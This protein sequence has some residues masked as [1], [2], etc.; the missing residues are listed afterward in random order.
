MSIKDKA[1]EAG[2]KAKA[3][4]EKAKQSAE[5]AYEGARTR[6]IKAYD[7]ARDGA[8]TARRK[9]GEG[10]ESNPLVA[11]GAGLGLGLIIGALIPRSQRE[12][13][14]LR[15]VG[16]DINNRAHGAFD[17]AKSAG[18]A[19]LKER[20]I[21]PEAAENVARDVARGIGEA[22]KSSAGAAT[23]AAKRKS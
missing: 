2:D 1:A 7:G 21:T 16:R 14:A 13:E 6:A 18:E 10:L 19:Q 4:A 9:T 8:A 17:A 11:L 12:K 3:T 23:E 20:G 5:R 15:S 22:A